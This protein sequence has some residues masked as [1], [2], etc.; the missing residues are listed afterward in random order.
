MKNQ[1][2]FRCDVFAVYDAARP[3]FSQC[4]RRRRGVVELGGVRHCERQKT[5]KACVL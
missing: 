5:D 3:P 1:V 4:P 2:S